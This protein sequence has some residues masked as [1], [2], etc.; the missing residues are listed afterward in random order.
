MDRKIVGIIQRHGENDFEYDFVEL[1]PEENEKVWEIANENCEGS[2]RGTFR[3]LLD[4]L[5][6]VCW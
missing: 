1:T 3:D 4:E 2:I 5:E 6:Y